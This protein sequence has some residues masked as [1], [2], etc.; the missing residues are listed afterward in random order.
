MSGTISTLP[1]FVDLRRYNQGGA[2]FK[3]PDIDRGIIGGCFPSPKQTSRPSIFSKNEL[4]PKYM[5]PKLNIKISSTGTNASFT[6]K[7]NTYSVD[8]KTGMI[9]RTNK[10]KDVKNYTNRNDIPDDL[11]DDF[12]EGKP[13]KINLDT[14]GSVMTL[15]PAADG[16]KIARATVSWPER[17]PNRNRN[18]WNDMVFR[19]PIMN[20]VSIEN[21]IRPTNS[22]V[23]GNITIAQQQN[24]V[25]NH[26]RSNLSYANSTSRAF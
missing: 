3:I 23:S 22:G 2:V 11:K 4:T 12:F 16:F 25:Q 13:V 20:E 9:T 8:Q 6:L 19:V 26:W 24:R 18:G 7:G 15:Y 5:W 10:A 14:K 17:E 1:K 21:V